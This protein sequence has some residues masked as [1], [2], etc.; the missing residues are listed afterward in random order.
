MRAIFS[1]IFF[2]YPDIRHTIKS[3]MVQHASFG[4]FFV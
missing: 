2:A 1:H 3:R 4:I